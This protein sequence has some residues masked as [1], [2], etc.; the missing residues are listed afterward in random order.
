MAEQK[1]Y[2]DVM[3]IRVMNYFRLRNQLDEKVRVKLIDNS[4]GDVRS[5]VELDQWQQYCLDDD[6]YGDYKM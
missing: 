1:V 4:S 2:Q 5:I 3:V 6:L